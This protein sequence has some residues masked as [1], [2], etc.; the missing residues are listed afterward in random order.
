MIN[1]PCGLV[2]PV[3][4]QPD[5]VIDQY[6]G[7]SA[8]IGLDKMTFVSADLYTQTWDLVYSYTLHI[9]PD[10]FG[11]SVTVYATGGPGRD[12]VSGRPVNHGADGFSYICELHQHS[13]TFIC[14][15]GHG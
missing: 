7:H 10:G 1:G 3:P 15:P 8:K 13:R 6:N 9:P 14:W 4:A 11:S 5:N 2:D 12:D